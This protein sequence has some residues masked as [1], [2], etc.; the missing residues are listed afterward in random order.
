[1]LELF[2]CTT[3]SFRR[4]VVSPIDV[5]WKKN[6]AHE[7]ATHGQSDLSVCILRLYLV[8]CHP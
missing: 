8:D 3:I 5:A 1:M 4:N 6:T 7:R 2:E